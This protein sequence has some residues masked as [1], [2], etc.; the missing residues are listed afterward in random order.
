[1][2][3]RYCRHNDIDFDKW[4]DCVINSLNA[5]VFGHVWYLNHISLSWE[6][7]VMGDYEAVM[8]VFCDADRMYMPYGMMWTGI[9]SKNMMTADICQEFMDFIDRR[10]KYVNITLDKYFFDNVRVDGRLSKEYIYQLDTFKG[11]SNIDVQGLV[12]AVNYNRYTCRDHIPNTV[13]AVI[14]SD[15]LDIDKSMSFKTAMSL[16]NLTNRAITY[17]FGCYA[18]LLERGVSPRGS[19]LAVF[20]DNYIFMPFF[21]TTNMTTDASFGRILLLSHIV[22]KYFAHKPGILVIDSQKCGIPPQ[23]LEK[24]GFKKYA[25]CRYKVDMLTKITNLFKNNRQTQFS[26]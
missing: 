16:K 26:E 8:P 25:Y 13:K 14:Y 19:A 12:G 2:N 3:I 10:F 5:C 21:G 4:E 22:N 18:E 6:G 23:A 11:I 20:S 17:K 9:Y 15:L 7:L 1:M 24:M